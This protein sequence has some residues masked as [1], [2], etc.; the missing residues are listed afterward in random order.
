VEA[1]AHISLR[2]P[3]QG[4]KV[5]YEAAV[6]SRPMFNLSGP[7]GQVTCREFWNRRQ[8]RV[9]SVAHPKGGSHIRQTPVESA[10]ES[11]D[12]RGSSLQ[13][14][15][16]GYDSTEHSLDS[17]RSMIAREGTR[18]KSVQF[19]PTGSGPEDILSLST[20]RHGTDPGGP[21]GSCSGTILQRPTGFRRTSLAGLSSGIIG[22]ERDDGRSGAS[23]TKPRHRSGALLS[24][25]FRRRR[26]EPRFPSQETETHCRRR[27]A[28]KV[29]ISGP[30][31]NL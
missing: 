28:R 18:D 1:G 30:D 21:T 27:N 11:I 14:S 9:F 31:G 15:P 23:I 26:N 13:S 6:P 12:G 19:T 29:N 24:E 17:W 5:H 16:A 2:K 4:P 7:V 3:K 8:F 25:V 22:P 20:P 10:C